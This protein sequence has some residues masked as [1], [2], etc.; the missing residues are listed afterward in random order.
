MKYTLTGNFQ[1]DLGIFGLKIIL[2][3]FN[4]DFKTDEKYFI[5]VDKNPE[6]LLELILSKLIFDKGINYFQDKVVNELFKPK[7]F[8]KIKNDITELEYFGIKD[9]PI[10]KIIQLKNLDQVLGKLSSAIFKNLSK[11]I[12]GIESRQLPEI[13]EKGI[14][15]ILWAKSVELLNNILHNFQADRTVKGKDSYLKAVKKIH[16]ISDIKKKAC[17]FCNLHDGRPITRDCYF[18]AP[19]QLNAFWY[20]EPS[21]FICPYCIVINFAIT[22]TLAFFGKSTRNAVVVY[23][24]NLE[25]LSNL[26]AALENE[27]IEN[28][29]DVTSHIIEYEK[30]M[31]KK[32][33]VIDEL[34]VIEF[35][36]DGQN[37]DLNFYILGDLSIKKMIDLDD[38][39]KKLFIQKR[40]RLGCGKS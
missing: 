25:D 33:S 8:D 30:E 31:L 32:K 16:S 7:E 13:T 37:P 2:E 38:I 1:Y 36:I 5:E 29:G 35:F 12:N 20:N 27:L 14:E 21:I 26:N 22:Q 3:F 34:Q 18:F 39:L 15:D 24:S 10:D 28:I 4:E 23:R 40:K 11:L 9:F 17:S 19:S 6:Q